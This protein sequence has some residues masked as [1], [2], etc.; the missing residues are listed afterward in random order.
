MSALLTAAV[1]LKP[2][3]AKFKKAVVEGTTDATKDAGK[4]LETGM[5]DAGAKGGKAAGD[6]AGK[7]LADGVKK[8]AQDGGKAAVTELDKAGKESASKFQMSWDKLNSIGNKLTLGVTLPAIAASKLSL[9]AFSRYQDASSAAGVFY[10]DQAKA[11]EKFGQ[12]AAKSYGMSK[13]AV[14]ELANGLNPL[15]SQFAAADK[16]GSTAVEA[17]G[18]VGDMA[19]FFGGSVDEAATAVQSFLSGSSV[20]PIRRYGVFASEAAVQ[21]KAL[22]MG[23]VKADVSSAQLGATQARLADAQNKAREATAKYGAG[24]IEAQKAVAA[25][26]LAEEALAKVTEGH[27]PQLTEQQKIQARYALLMEQTSKSQGDFVRTSDSLANTQKRT[28][29]QMQNAAITLGQKL[30]PSAIKV[31]QAVTKLINVF[32]H[33][34]KVAQNALLVM[35][36]FAAV[37]G[38]LIKLATIVRGMWG[39]L[40]TLAA[41]WG[42]VTA[43]ANAAAIAQER[44]ALSGAGAG[45]AGRLG[46]MAGLAGGLGMAAAVAGGIFG[47]SYLGEALS[48]TS[49]GQS[50]GNFI[51]D[52][53]VLGWAAFNLGKILHGITGAGPD[54]DGVSGPSFMAGGGEVDRAGWSWVGERGPELRYMPQGAKVISNRDSMAMAGGPSIG[55]LS[56]TIQVN[57]G[58]FDERQLA[59]HIGRVFDERLAQV[60]RRA[61]ATNTRTRRPVR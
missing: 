39:V 48:K 38:P 42:L 58:S 15:I 18:R 27:L 61:A 36:G 16:Q 50:A 6:A 34:P 49:A 35:A 55:S 7:G 14:L 30:A 25:V 4:K 33:L 9:D 13:V 2:D 57:G 45:T 11:I 41:R 47:G 60:G 51:A 8:G 19:S 23:L 5:K 10:G 53:P 29:A 24:S 46:G 40:A 12:T 20:E 3:L 54:S 31:M 43:S 44:A 59:S 21:A 52:T 22:A 1:E 56:M 37:A 28:T 26:G 32:T 17:M